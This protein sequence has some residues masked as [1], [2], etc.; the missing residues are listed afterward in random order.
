MVTG[1]L[2]RLVVFLSFFL[3]LSFIFLLDR[4]IIKKK[5]V[6]KHEFEYEYNFREKVNESRSGLR[7]TV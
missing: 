4:M 5:G 6:N 2:S 3:F 1:R 7:V